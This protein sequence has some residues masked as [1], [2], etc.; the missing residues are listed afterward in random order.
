M[1]AMRKNKRLNLQMVTKG[2]RERHDLDYQSITK[3]LNK[4]GITLE[5]N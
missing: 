2:R 4:W 5:E 3:K 1:H